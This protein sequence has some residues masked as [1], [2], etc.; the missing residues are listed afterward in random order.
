MDVTP[1]VCFFFVVQKTVFSIRSPAASGT[2]PLFRLWIG[3]VRQ[4]ISQ[5]LSS[6]IRLYQA[7]GFRIRNIHADNESECVRESLSPYDN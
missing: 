5:A 2:T 6:T 4:T 3:H 1:C 7:R